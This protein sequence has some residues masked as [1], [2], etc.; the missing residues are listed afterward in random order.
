MF[1]CALKFVVDQYHN[2]INN[3]STVSIHMEMKHWDSSV[4][5]PHANERNDGGVLG[6]HNPGER[7]KDGY[8]NSL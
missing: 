1:T 6:A 3:V 5:A 4:L 2:N 7:D 8:G